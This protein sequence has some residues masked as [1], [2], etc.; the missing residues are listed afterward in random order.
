MR[1]DH[2]CEDVRAAGPRVADR[3]MEP[4]LMSKPIPSKPIPSTP[5][6][7]KPIPPTPIP[8]RTWLEEF[9]AAVRERDYERGRAMF[10]P[11]AVGFGTVARGMLLCDDRPSRGAWF[12]AAPAC[13]AAG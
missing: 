12:N 13:C 5:I 2:T 4:G 8:M 3:P 1:P 7:S 6:P 9:A 10:A 11:E